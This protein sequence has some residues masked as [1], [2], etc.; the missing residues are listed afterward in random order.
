MSVPKTSDNLS[1]LELG[2]KRYQ[3]LFSHP[4]IVPG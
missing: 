3:L 4:Q 1:L 2:Q